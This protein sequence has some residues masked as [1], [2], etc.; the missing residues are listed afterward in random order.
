MSRIN[1]I[2]PSH[3]SAPVKPM[4]D[5]VQASLGTV[6]NF[7][8]ALANSPTA[9]EGFLGLFAI[10]GKG[11]LDAKT[12]EQIAL[13]IAEQNSCQ[14]CVSAH[15]VLGHGVGLNDAEITAARKGE[16][17]E[18]KAAAAVA[19]AKALATSSG[20]VTAAEFEAAKATLGDAEI[21]EVI[22]HVALNIFTNLI[23]KSTKVAIDFP[24]IEL[25]R[26][27]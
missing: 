14:Y 6:P 9:L 1:L 21:M 13:A 11:V 16:A 26:A 2:D 7:V 23:G 4:F 3:A 22:A 12:R 5:A 15:T 20:D 17:S 10:S 24:Q 25:L 27:A 19:F 8:R 18:P